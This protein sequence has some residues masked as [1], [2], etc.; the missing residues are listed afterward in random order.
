M[1]RSEKGLQT[2]KRTCACCCAD[3]E[4]TYQTIY[5]I[6]SHKHAQWDHNM[7]DLFQKQSFNN[8]RLYRLLKL[9]SQPSSQVT[10]KQRKAA[11]LT[12]LVKLLN[13]R[14]SF[15]KERIFFLLQPGLQVTR[16]LMYLYSWIKQLTLR[17]DNYT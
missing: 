8:S 2:L 16:C 1:L 14:G 15:P 17:S 6:P 10:V 5:Y 13:H 4:K 3:K 11:N 12:E 7:Y 9:H